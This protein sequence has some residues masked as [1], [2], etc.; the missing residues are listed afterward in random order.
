MRDLR[1]DRGK[2]YK[3]DKRETR[4]TGK[5]RD[6]LLKIETALRVIIRRLPNVRKIPGTGK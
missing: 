3:R 1:D 4:E 2:R 5:T 6:N